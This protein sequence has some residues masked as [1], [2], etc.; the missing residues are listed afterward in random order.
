MKCKFL[1]HGLAIGYDSVVKPCCVWQV[2]QDWKN[3]NHLTQVSLDQ[4]HESS[5]MI[6]IKN[7]L[8]QKIT[9]STFCLD[10]DSATCGYLEF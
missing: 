10:S 3:S 7:Q 2:D 9:A 8:D 6:A 1:D 5:T 4:W